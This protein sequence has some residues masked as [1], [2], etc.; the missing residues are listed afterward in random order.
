MAVGS[1]VNRFNSRTPCGVRR[2]AS[3]APPLPRKFQFT[4]PVWGATVFITRHNLLAQV[5]I[6]APR[7]GCDNII[8]ISIIIISRFQ[9][10]HPVWGATYPHQPQSYDAYRFNS[11]TPCGVRR[12]SSNLSFYNTRFNSRT[13]CGVRLLTPS[14]QIQ[15]MLVSIH[16]PRVGCDLLLLCIHLR[17]SC[18]NSRTPCGVRH[19]PLSLDNPRR[20]F[21]F[22]HPVWGATSLECV[23][24]RRSMFQFTHPVWGATLI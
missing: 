12:K 15:S 10:T 8:A 20:R 16:A 11:R 24:N 21:Q 9:F 13:P 14:D 3:P 2:R 23:T 19:D 6:H 7:V 22:T 4:H 18:F 1:L 17:F 5:S